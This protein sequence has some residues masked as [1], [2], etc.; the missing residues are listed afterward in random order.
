MNRIEIEVEAIQLCGCEA[1]NCL[2]ILG[3]EDEIYACFA[4]GYAGVTPSGAAW[5][6]VE[7]HIGGLLAE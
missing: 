2:E 1:G 6:E 3:L 7:I 4:C 5:P